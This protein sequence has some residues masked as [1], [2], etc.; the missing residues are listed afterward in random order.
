MSYE[1]SWFWE[2]ALWIA[3]SNEFIKLLFMIVSVRPL[4]MAQHFC[5]LIVK[6][7]QASPYF[8]IYNSNDNA[9]S[10]LFS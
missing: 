5:F 1:Y 9:Q 3:L 8:G 7:R 6:M 2:L 10:M 4:K